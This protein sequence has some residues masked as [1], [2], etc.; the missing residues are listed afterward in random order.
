M[1]DG[2]WTVYLALCGDDTLYCGITTDAE[3]RVAEHNCG[4]GARYT[5][6]RTPVK[7]VYS[8]CHADRA[9]ALKRE[10]AIKQMTRQEKE[11]LV[12]HGSS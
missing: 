10:Y 9:S 3:R 12:A 1:V 2:S 11:D 8:E 4:Q 5:R 7:L 6:A